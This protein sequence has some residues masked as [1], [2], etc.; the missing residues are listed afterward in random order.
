MGKEFEIPEVVE[1]AAT[2]EQVWD[3][4]ATGPGIDCWFM[5]RTEVL[6]GEGGAVRTEFG[7]AI[8]ESL[9][10]T[11]RPFEQLAHRSATGE[12]GRFVAYE[13]LIEGRGGGSTVLRAVTSGFLPGDDW[14][15][16]YEAMGFGQALFFRTLAEYLTHFPGRAAQPVTA[17]G[18]VIGDWPAAWDRLGRALGLG[19]PARTG[20][21]VTVDGVKG[22]VYHVSEQAVAVR[23][24][25]ALFRFLRG[26]PGPIL[27]TH[28]VF[29]ATGKTGWR[30]W[31]YDVFEG[32]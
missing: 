6:P 28:H 22:V 2:P 31:L 4:I 23:T 13:F 24:P 18:P 8:P 17:I 27:A 21:T 12:D 9:V 1:V 20:D 19:G 16:E 32:A 10:T 15:D 26:L 11:W 29:G 14:A 30:A 5:G 25:D 3:A 7:G